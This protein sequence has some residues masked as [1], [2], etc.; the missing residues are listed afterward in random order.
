MLATSAAHGKDTKVF[1]LPGDRAQ[2]PRSLSRPPP[3]AN[4]A[5]QQEQE[6]KNEDF[7]RP[8]YYIIL[9]TN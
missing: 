9:G 5:A 6:I 7:V 8:Y 1:L 4:P 2:P 3:S